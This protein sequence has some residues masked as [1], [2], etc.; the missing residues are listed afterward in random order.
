MSGCMRELLGRNQLSSD[1]GMLF[2]AGPLLPL[3]WMH[4]FFMTFPIDL[5]FI[6]RSDIVLKIQASLKPWRLSAIV[7]GARKAIELS[8]GA[9]IKAETAVSDV[10]S[11]SKL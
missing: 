3:M 6:G 1:Q 4:T 2:E 9:A 7:F 11:L 8:A 5:V 10:I